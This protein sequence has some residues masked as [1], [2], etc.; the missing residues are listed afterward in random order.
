MLRFPGITEM[1]ENAGSH[2]GGK[3]STEPWSD[4]IQGRSTGQTDGITID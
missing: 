1:V 2:R 3:M 4:S